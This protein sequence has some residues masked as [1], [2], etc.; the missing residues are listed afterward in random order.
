MADENSEANDDF[1][2][3]INIDG[4]FYSEEVDKEFTAI[5]PEH[6][7]KCEK[8]QKQTFLHHHTSFC[9]KCLRNGHIPAKQPMSLSLTIR[10]SKCENQI[11][12]SR[13]FDFCRDTCEGEGEVV[14]DRPKVQD[15]TEV[16][17]LRLKH[18]KHLKQLRKAEKQKAREQRRKKNQKRKLAKNKEIISNYFL[19]PSDQVGAD[20]EVAQLGPVGSVLREIIVQNTW[21]E[22][23]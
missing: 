8:C 18:E 17:F 13:H 9:S 6:I 10:C 23:D 12:Q 20:K 21:L 11:F 19:S 16:L 1:N 3:G 22:D 15:N 14:T 2:H 4:D 5:K 7:I